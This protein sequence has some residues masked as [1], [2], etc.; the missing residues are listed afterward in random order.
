MPTY[1][2]RETR[3]TLGSI[4]SGF[5]D[6][7]FISIERNEDTHATHVGGDGEV[8]F[9]R[10]SDDSGTCTLRIKQTASFNAVLSALL[11]G[12]TLVP[13]LL[14]S[15]NDVVEVNEC[16]VVNFGTVTYGTEE[17]M[18]EWKILLTDLSRTVL[19]GN[20]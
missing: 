7:D 20:D 15:G 5:A 10:H 2:P 14:M 9:T 16:R 19:A 17:S 11:A 18:R 6:G 8:S 12:G 13:F 3:L 4:V 1:A